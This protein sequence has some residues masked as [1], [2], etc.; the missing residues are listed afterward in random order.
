MFKGTSDFDILCGPQRFR[1]M[2]DPIFPSVGTVPQGALQICF[3]GV[4]RAT[5]CLYTRRSD[6]LSREPLNQEVEKQ[7]ISFFSDLH[8]YQML[9][10]FVKWIRGCWYTIKYIPT[11]IVLS[12]D[13]LK[14]SKEALNIQKMLSMGTVPRGQGLGNSWWKFVSDDSIYFSWTVGKDLCWVQYSWGELVLFRFHFFHLLN[15]K[16]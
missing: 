5:F 4:L 13:A 9:F 14:G 2:C 16:K 7:P 3:S 15:K 11:L 12:M 8:H 10:C 1:F 6:T